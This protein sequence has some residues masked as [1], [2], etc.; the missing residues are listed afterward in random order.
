M[1]KLAVEDVIPERTLEQYDTWGPESGRI[2][3]ARLDLS[4]QEEEWARLARNRFPD[5][6]Y[7]GYNS[8]LQEFTDQLWGPTEAFISKTL[9]PNWGYLRDAPDDN[10]Y[11]GLDDLEDRFDSIVGESDIESRIEQIAT[12]VKTKA[13]ADLTAEFEQAQIKT[14]TPYSGKMNQFI[15]A[16]IHE[17]V[18]LVKTI[19]AQYHDDLERVISE[20]VR[21]NW[22]IDEI[23]EVIQDRF[24]VAA[25]R[26][27]TIAMDQTNSLYSAI[28]RAQHSEI[29]LKR[30]RW[31]AVMDD[32]TRPSHA[33]RH[34]TVYTWESGA[35]G[36]YPGG[37]I[38]CRCIAIAVKDEL[39]RVAQDQQA[40]AVA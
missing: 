32:R 31:I 20:G 40:L 27:R 28:T 14:F 4:E 8:W 17:N 21:S 10:I 1:T 24:D 12:Q 23:E 36:A 25:S 34:G 33:N 18:K 3:V 16:S 26:T 39:V 37:S 6:I 2:D 35:D 9:R 19:P 30:F 11:K 5:E 29:G 7:K 22:A 38:N 13:V 15:R